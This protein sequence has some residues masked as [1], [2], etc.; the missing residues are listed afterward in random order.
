MFLVGLHNDLC[1]PIILDD[2]KTKLFKPDLYYKKQN[3]LNN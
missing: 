3:K 1:L 2:Y